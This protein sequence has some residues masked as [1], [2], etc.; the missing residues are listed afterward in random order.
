M[1]WV[2]G[3]STQ[4]RIRDACNIVPRRERGKWAES[5]AEFGKA[6]LVIQVEHVVSR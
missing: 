2:K 4:R 6:C 3:S 5:I 1:L